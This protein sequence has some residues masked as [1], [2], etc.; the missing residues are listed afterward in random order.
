MV[1]VLGDAH[2]DDPENRRA[3][4]AAYEAAD[5]SLA[6]Q[7][8][9]LLW[10]DLPIPT[11]F[12][13]GNNEDFDAIDAMRRGDRTLTDGGR[14]TLL[15]SSAA[16][17]AGLRVA[18]L[19]GNYA[20]TKYGR[21]REELTGDRRRHYT[22]DEVERAKALADE[23]DVDVLLTHEPPHGVVRVAGGRD[24]GVPPVDEL[25]RALSPSLCLVGHTH[26]HAEAELGGT[27]V[28]SLAP[29]WNSYYTLDPETLDV[30]R[31]RT[32][33]GRDE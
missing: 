10:Y 19:S 8:G 32:P 28:V 3:L 29:V 23:G 6:L 17:V 13:A 24:P 9:D 22:R 25:V 30:R 1:L 20:P 11:W 2:A 12:V 27:R 18:G 15:A 21:S 7:I 31:H 33:V 5:E 16:E 26:R 4:C 14:P